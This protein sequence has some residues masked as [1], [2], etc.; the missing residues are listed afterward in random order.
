MQLPCFNVYREL[1]YDANKKKIVP[2]NIRELLT[3]RGLAF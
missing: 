3:P 1:F 2:E